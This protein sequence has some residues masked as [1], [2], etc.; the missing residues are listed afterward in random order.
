[1]G[2]TPTHREPRLRSLPPM[3]RWLPEHKLIKDADAVGDDRIALALL[4]LLRDL[5][6]W[7]ES[8]DQERNA[9]LLPAGHHRSETIK[10]AQLKAPE[11]EEPL[12]A[13]AA[14]RSGSCRVS[15]QSLG[16]AC[17]RISKWAERRSLSR[18]A[19]LFAEAAARIEQ[20]TSSVATRAGRVARHA[21]YP[22][23]AEC[24]Y[25]RGIQ[26]AAR[27]GS[28]RRRDKLAALLGKATLLRDQ[29]RFDEARRLLT[30]A[31]RLSASTRR[32]RLA[33]E[34]QHDLYA[35]AVMTGALGE[36]ENH[37]VQALEHYPVHHPAIPG[38]IHDWCFLL[39]Q[40]GYYSQAVSLLQAS[41]PH[42]RRLEIKLVCWGTLSRAAAGAGMKEL[43]D[44]ALQ[45]IH[46]LTERTHDY[47]AAALAHA[48]HGARFFF[49]WQSALT[50]AMRANE[51][52]EARGEMDVVH[53][54][55]ELL[56]AIRARETPLP[57][58]DPPERS[59]TTEICQQ[60]VSLLLARQRPTRRP[61]SR[62]NDREVGGLLV[63]A[64]RDNASS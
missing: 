45:H 26:L 58:T 49:D 19:L 25:D 50:L 29:R 62:S 3:P 2:Q 51:I 41:L 46:A 30:S 12:H 23:R 17:I 37:M 1:M 22:D 55:Q 21:G 33:A 4:L 7:A 8:S 61:V 42:I 54:I 60:M 39:V 6:L 57:L 10:L 44:E 9:L 28:R 52:A 14:M 35:L 32:H 53:G 56:G 20:E 63:P 15:S 13:L 38:L 31:A 34:T 18:V 47:A 36:A 64:P 11:I 48:A 24:W 27:N 40:N 16:G 43:Y 5:R 59:R